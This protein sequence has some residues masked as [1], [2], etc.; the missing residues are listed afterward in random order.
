[1]VSIGQVGEWIAL[2]VVIALNLASEFVSFTKVIDAT[3]PLRFV[4]RLG[5]IP[6]RPPLNRVLLNSRLNSRPRSAASRR[7][8][9]ICC[10]PV[11]GSPESYMRRT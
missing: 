10:S 7:G 11:V 4:D 8:V 9:A 3:P 2:V 1:M 5:S 6:E